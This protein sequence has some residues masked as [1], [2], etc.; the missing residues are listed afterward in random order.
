MLLSKSVSDRDEE[1]DDI[2]GKHR[3]EQPKSYV[4]GHPPSPRC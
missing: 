1:H 2:R 4:K 3:A